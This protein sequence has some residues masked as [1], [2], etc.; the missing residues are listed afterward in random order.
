MKKLMMFTLLLTGF[1]VN[2]QPIV[3]PVAS[4]DY[5][6]IDEYKQRLP[7]LANANTFPRTISF[8][9]GYA[10][11]SN[12]KANRIIGANE[13]YWTL[14]GAQNITHFYVE[15]SRDMR[16]FEQAGIVHLLRVD[17]GYNYVF[18]HQFN[19]QSLVYYRLA[20]VRDG[21]ILA[22]TPAVQ[23]LDEEATT[24]VFP[25]VVQGSTVYI[26]TG[27][28]YEKLEVV[29][30]ASQSVFQKGLG[31][32]TGTITVGLPALQKGIYFV[33]LLSDRAPQHVQRILVE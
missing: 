28:P 14:S 7:E 32:Q 23:V 20:F 6:E 27:I 33:R 10:G 12:V 4:G 21:Q 22:Y 18:R 1:V 3:Q 11:V 30:T 5:W 29:N 8:A 24:K 26:K 31:N 19:D 9:N 17:P 15:Y 16:R 25:T 13:I 2:A